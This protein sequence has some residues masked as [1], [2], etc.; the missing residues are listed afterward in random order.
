M[1]ADDYRIAI[2]GKTNFEARPATACLRHLDE[3]LQSPRV[4]ES[5]KMERRRR[6][7]DLIS[8]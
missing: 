3:F 6:S 2:I 5:L 8:R 4:G 1:A 7:S